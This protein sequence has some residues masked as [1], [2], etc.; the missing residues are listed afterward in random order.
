MAAS[1]SFGLLQLERELCRGGAIAGLE[2]GLR[3]RFELLHVRLVGGDL[4]GDPLDEPAVLLEAGAPFLELLDGAV[5]LVSHLGHRI[6][7]PE[8]VRDL[9][10]LRHERGPELVENHGGSF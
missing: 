4:P 3:L 2:V 9:V 7:L 5:V 10:D 1:S 8:D 6:G